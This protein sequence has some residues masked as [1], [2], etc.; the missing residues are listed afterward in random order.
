MTRQYFYYLSLIAVLISAFVT[1]GM[2]YS[3]LPN[4]YQAA[5]QAQFFVDFA[6]Y[7]SGVHHLCLSLFTPLGT[8]CLLAAFIF[9]FTVMIQ[10]AMERNSNK[11][12]QAKEQIDAMDDPTLSEKWE[13]YQSHDLN[14]LLPFLAP[15]LRI[16]LAIFV[17][18]FFVRGT[19]LPEEPFSAYYYSNIP[20]ATYFLYRFISMDASDR[21]AL[22]GVINILLIVL[23]L[24]VLTPSVALF[25]TIMSSLTLAH[26]YLRK[27]R[28]TCH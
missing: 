7:L 3:E 10:F 23:S 28:V 9:L 4:P 6:V 24:L 27:E 25:I 19:L 26:E 14:L 11:L 1:R 12:R 15:F 8:V 16:G 21:L 22:A 5:H 18:I 13:V 20:C 17:V 2:V